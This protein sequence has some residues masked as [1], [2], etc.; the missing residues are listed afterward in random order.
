[1]QVLF[2]LLRAIGPTGCMFLAM[3]GFYEGIPGLN[4]IKV[5]ADIPIVGDIALG[6][7]ELAKRSAVEGMVAR[8]ELVALQ[9]TADEERRLR[10]I[11]EDAAAADRERASALA[12][13]AAE[14]QTALDEREADARA[15]PGVTYPSPEDL[16]WLQK[17]L[18]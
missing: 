9:A 6:R 2:E 10:Q 4:R 1:M 12:K 15:T 13:L 7:V 16:K 3:L 18:Q 11:A 17:R 14:R 5:L 8:A